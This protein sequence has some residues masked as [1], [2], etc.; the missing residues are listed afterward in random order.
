MEELASEFIVGTCQLLP[1]SS[2]V[3]FGPFYMYQPCY[4]MYCGSAV[5][6][7]IQPLHSCIA[8]V[9]ALRIRTDDLAFTGDFPELPSDVSC[10]RDSIKC[11][12]I[13]PHLT[14]PGFVR[15]RYIGEVNY[16]WK[17]KNHQFSRLSFPNNYVTVI[18]VGNVRLEQ[19]MTKTTS[20]PAIK[21]L[22]FSG[23]DVLDVVG[24]VWCPQWPK[25]AKFW[26]KRPRRNAWP[27]I[28]AISEVVRNG[29]H[30]VYVQHRA[31]RDDKYQFRLSFS[32]A[33]VILLQS[34]TKTQQITYHL[35]RFFARREL[36]LK[37]CPKEDEVFCMY[38]LKTLMLWTCEEIPSR[39]WVSSSII[40]ICSM[41]LKK[42]SEWLSRRNVPNY[43]I[44]EANLFHEP[45]SSTMFDKTQRKLNEF[46]DSKILC[47]WFVNNYIHHF[48]DRKVINI[49]CPYYTACLQSLFTFWSER[50]PLS[51]NIFFW[52]VLNYSNKCS[53][54]AI[55]SGGLRGLFN[56][57][58]FVFDKKISFAYAQENAWI[59]SSEERL[60]FH[61]P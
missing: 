24:C 49:D 57:R 53:R 60:V 39:W 26:P 15:L 33:E 52:F 18:A 5:E 21:L 9:D 25:E 2:N 46:S 42:L 6:F 14:Y 3:V 45:S 40:T 47:N 44:P 31:C 13:E 38:H 56:V 12:Q 35:L 32:A 27:D 16:N 34:W 59:K 1:K 51:L 8:D 30:V 7:Y 61:L 22:I 20:G 43:F 10:L 37:D 41:L 50:E 29:C 54:T 28:Y 48:T 58:S 11:Y 4:A 17:C 19:G 36:I 23:T 55:K